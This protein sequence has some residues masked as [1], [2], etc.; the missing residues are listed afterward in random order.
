LSTREVCRIAEKAKV[1]HSNKENK[2][3]AA[4]RKQAEAAAD[5]PSTRS[6]RK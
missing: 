2:V 3:L 4:S 5:K 1:G 6:R